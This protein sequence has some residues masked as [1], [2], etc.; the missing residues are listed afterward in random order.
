MTG[1]T[2]HV[3]GPHAGRARREAQELAELRHAVDDEVA[4]A[5]REQHEHGHPGE[6][7]CTAGRLP[8]ATLVARLGVDGAAVAGTHVAGEAGA[9]AQLQPGN[10]GVGHVAQRGH[11]AAA[12]DVGR[13]VHHQSE[14]RPDGSD[15]LAEAAGERA[16]Q[17]LDHGGDDELEGDQRQ[18]AGT[19]ERDD[20]AHAGTRSGGLQRE[21]GPALGE[22]LAV[23]R[24]GG[25]HHQHAGAAEVRAPAQV[26]VVTL[27][28]DG[29]VEPS[30]GAEQVGA[31]EQA[32]RRHS[33]HVAHGIVLLLVVLAGLDERIDLAEAVDAEAHVLQH[34][35]LV[36]GDQLGADDAGVRSVELLHQQ[37]DGA[38]VECDVVVQ[39]AEEPVVALDEA[40]HLVRRGAEAG[41][42]T[43]GANEGPRHV[44]TDARRQLARLAGHQEQVLQVAV[45]LPGQPLEHLVEP[46][47]GV[48]HH[49]HCHDGRC[50][51]LGGFHEETRLAGTP[52]RHGSPSASAHPPLKDTLR[53]RT[54]SA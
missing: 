39:E 25:G 4:A 28:L 13:R 23:A 26:D 6:R 2:R 38:L 16:D 9:A 48:V 24:A 21:V 15:R 43:D 32:R 36:P 5:D 50:D 3:V 47:T 8:P 19:G 1:P 34:R 41:V 53:P 51:L 10:F 12:G 45:V 29:R 7:G 52:L 30:D 46:L 37:A 14:Q 18:P 40:Q 49:H 54:L 44:G 27:V 42:P 20:A 22:C 31:H 35:R 11:R 17:R 33:E